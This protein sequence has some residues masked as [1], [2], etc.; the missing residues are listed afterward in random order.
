LPAA[1]APT[2][3]SISEVPQAA[4]PRTTARRNA[5]GE[6]RTIKAPPYVR[7][8]VGFDVCIA[9]DRT[10]L[11]ERDGS[12]KNVAQKDTLYP[13]TL[14]GLRRAR[15]TA[16]RAGTSPPLTILTASEI[17]HR[18]IEAPLDGDVFHAVADVNRRR[19]IDALGAG[20]RPSATWWRKWGSRTLP[21]R[22]IS[23]SCTEPGWSSAGRTAFDASTGSTARP[24]G[25]CMLGSTNTEVSGAA[26]SLAA[27][28]RGDRK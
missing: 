22:S 7:C 3:G 19:L 1:S 28:L 24:F 25:T 12:R 10:D 9:F 18:M 20:E 27:P 16:E 21:C 8:R 15:S 5:F 6:F 13:R 14:D 2:E 23:R 11:L 4:S 17:V 26:A